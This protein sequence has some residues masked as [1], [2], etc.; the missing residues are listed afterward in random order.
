MVWWAKWRTEVL[1]NK[2]IIGW[3]S[4]KEGIEMEWT[5][6]LNGKPVFKNE[7]LKACTA[8]INKN[9]ENNADNRV[10]ISRIKQS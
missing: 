4:P 8:Y 10:S 2:H 3:N 1:I 9:I 6:K 5:V 7:S